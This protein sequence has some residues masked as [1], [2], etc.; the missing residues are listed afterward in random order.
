[1]MKLAMALVLGAG[2]TSGAW[3]QPSSVV[4]GPHNLS[5]S[6]TGRVRAASEDEVCIFCHTPHNASPVR[7]LWNR[8]FSPDAY[9]I[10]ASRALDARPGQ[11]T[12]VSKMCLSCHDGTIALGSVLSRDM[13]IAMAGGV[14]TMPAGGSNLGTDLRD[15]HPVS[16]RYDTSLASKDPQLRSPRAL[17]HEVR[18]DSNAELQ[19]SSCHD[20][21]DNSR[22]KFLVMKNTNSE[23]CVSCHQVGTTQITAHRDCSACHQPH[24]AP[25][26]PYLL[27]K[28]TITQ[29][30]TSCHDGTVSGAHDIA[31][32]L[33]K[34]SVH[35]TGAAVDPAGPAQAQASCVDCHEPHTMGRGSSPA[36]G[37][38]ANFGRI[39][40]VNASGS[41]M[42]AANNE[43][44]V[45][46]KCHADR[47]AIQPSVPRRIAQNNT[48][49]EFAPSAVSFHPVMAPGKNAE[50]PSLRPGW[51]V[52][53]VMQCS[54][55][56]ASDSGESA[57]GAGA[58]GTHGSNASPLLVARYETGDFMAESASA[59]ALCYK[60]HDRSNI[61]SDA[62][63][64]LHRKHIVDERTACAACHDGH[65]IASSQGSVFNNSNLINFATDVVFP[66]PVTGRMEF[67]DTGRLSGECFLRCHSVSHSP[68]RYPS[69]SPLALPSGVLPPR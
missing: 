29:T 63:F 38:H 54:D 21:H 37:V 42:A 47:N 24:S 9:S 2:M 14:T 55:C 68:A 59:Y 23:L 48:R 34:L 50:V 69:G 61:L 7:P 17:P 8:S 16:F 13:P 11:P 15:D 60:C 22:G 39:D 62:S 52:A 32:D 43:Y 65:G 3:G 44:E 40:G 64:P 20:A 19:C 18:L 28:P 46:F 12:G 25:S 57:G 41:P 5:A 67:R 30:C 58:D 27:R 66:D 51:T 35:D 53:S 26:G 10:Y 49:L 56:H 4:N 36:P 33:R 31:S 1:M 45:C 6:G